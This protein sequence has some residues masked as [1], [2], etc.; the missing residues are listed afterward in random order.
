MFKLVINFLLM[1]SCFFMTGCSCQNYKVITNFDPPIIDFVSM[2]LENCD[3]EIV[4]EKS[5]DGS[6][7][8]YKDNKNK[9]FVKLITE[10]T[11]STEN[12]PENIKK[13]FRVW[14]LDDEL[15]AV[16][17]LSDN[18]VEFIG[19]IKNNK[20]KPFIK[21][22]MDQFEKINFLGERVWKIYKEKS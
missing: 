2:V 13:Y 6:F 19:F 16:Y 5:R 4:I 17:Q 22:N 12:F 8:Y 14:I 15:E 21:E 11:D 18:K 9:F 1:A 7:N 10:T 20:F 3:R